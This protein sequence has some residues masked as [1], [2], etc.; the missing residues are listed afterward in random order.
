LWTRFD[1]RKEWDRALHNDEVKL[2]LWKG[3]G[4]A[5]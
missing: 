2:Y 3:A 1:T 5:R 4:A